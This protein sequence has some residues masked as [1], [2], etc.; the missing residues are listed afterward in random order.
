[1][2]THFARSP[3]NHMLGAYIYTMSLEGFITAN[4]T[5]HRHVRVSLLDKPYITILWFKEV[6][7]TPSNFGYQKLDLYYQ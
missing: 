4:W 3:I 6:F 7:Q 5:V 1:M 2:W